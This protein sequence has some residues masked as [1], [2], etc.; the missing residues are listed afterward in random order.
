MQD[1]AC[2]ACNEFEALPPL[3]HN[4]GNWQDIHHRYENRLR[5]DLRRHVAFVSWFVDTFTA[6][7]YRGRTRIK[8]ELATWIRHA[9]HRARRVS[10]GEEDHTCSGDEEDS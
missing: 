4:D 8:S 7:L 10:R 3:L 1:M 5:N 2:P 9:G 6:R